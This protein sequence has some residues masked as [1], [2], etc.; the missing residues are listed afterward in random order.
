VTA[1]SDDVLAALYV[2]AGA[3]LGALGYLLTGSYEASEELM[4]AAI[5]KTFVTRRRL[6][7]VPS[8]E[9]YV[10]ATMRTLHIDRIRREALWKRF[11]PALVGGAS[12]PD[13]QDA[14][15]DNDAVARAL[16]QLAPR[17]R[18]AVA[19]H[20]FDDLSVRDVAHQM[21]LS[22]GT[23]KGYLK[24]GRARLAPLLPIDADAE[25]DVVP[26]KGAK[27]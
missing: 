15:A 4:Q 10:R 18:T 12:A 23:V 6:P 7:D 13:S 24:E 11:I 26:V 22:E 1:D 14:T 19:L 16:A 27:R 20:Y 21:R 8:A 9:A 25:T 2:Q 17:V 5:V 3:R